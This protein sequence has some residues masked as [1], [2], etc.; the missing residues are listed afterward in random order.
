[1]EVSSLFSKPVPG[2]LILYKT[3]PAFGMCKNALANQT[4]S[5]QYSSP[6]EVPML[7]RDENKSMSLLILSRFCT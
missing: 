5:F 2:L 3:D 4:Q 1:M 7:A 6:K